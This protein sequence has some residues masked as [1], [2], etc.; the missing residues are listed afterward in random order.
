VAI[1]KAA[2]PDAASEEFLSRAQ[3]EAEGDKVRLASFCQLGVGVVHLCLLEAESATARIALIRRLRSAAEDFGGTLVVE[4]CHWDIK[5]RVDVWGATGDVSA[6]MA[7]VK[8]AWDPK[9]TLAPG[10][11]VNGL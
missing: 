7:K 6:V 8:A 2:L 1:L 4:H 10:R 11:F 9:G 3:Q 5:S